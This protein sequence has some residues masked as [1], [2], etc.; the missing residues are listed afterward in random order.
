MLLTHCEDDKAARLKGV[1]HVVEAASWQQICSKTSRA[2]HNIKRSLVLCWHPLL[3]NDIRNDVLVVSFA[4]EL[5]N[6]CVRALLTIDILIALLRQ[7][8]AKLAALGPEIQYLR[9]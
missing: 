2:C 1:E 8:L 9:I 4:L 7:K 5:L 3:A 6:L